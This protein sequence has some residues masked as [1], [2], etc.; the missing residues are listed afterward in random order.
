MRLEDPVSIIY[1]R[2][3][4]MAEYIDSEG[5]LEQ[6]NRSTLT[7]IREILLPFEHPESLSLLA[8]IAGWGLATYLTITRSCF[9]TERHAFR[10]ASRAS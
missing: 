2:G 10:L 4:K 3:R 6:D 9:Q 8:A 5:I 7:I 1:K